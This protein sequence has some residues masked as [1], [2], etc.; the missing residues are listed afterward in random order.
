MPGVPQANVLQAGWVNLIDGAAVPTPYMIANHMI[1][2]GVTGK[3]MGIDPK[4]GAHLPD[5]RQYEGQ[6]LSSAEFIRILGTMTVPDP[7]AAKKQACLRWF[8]NEVGTGNPVPPAD[9]DKR[10]LCAMGLVDLYFNVKTVLPWYTLAQAY[11]LVDAA[12]PKYG[13]EAYNPCDTNIYPDPVP[14]H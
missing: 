4:Y 7:V 5:I 12:V 8:G 2:A 10:S 13:Q 6:D 1:A 14:H 3:N 11:A 9:A